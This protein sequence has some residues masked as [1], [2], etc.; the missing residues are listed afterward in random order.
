MKKSIWLILHILQL[1]EFKLGY[2]A[3]EIAQN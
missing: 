2:G 3:P 1:C